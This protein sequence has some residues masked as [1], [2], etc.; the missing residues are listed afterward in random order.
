MSE[1]G[2]WSPQ[3]A[4]LSSFSITVK[5]RDKGPPEAPGPSKMKLLTNVHCRLSPEVRHLEPCTSAVCE[6][7]SVDFPILL[8]GLL[9]P[10][11]KYKVLAGIQRISL[12][13]SAD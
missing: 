6:T 11:L 2:P 13:T 4:S 8:S 7:Q 9:G 3:A 5:T 12:H 10:W 1:H